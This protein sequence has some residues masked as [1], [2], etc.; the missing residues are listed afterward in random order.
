[1]LAR[2]LGSVLPT[3]RPTNGERIS[4]RMPTGAVSRP[5][6]GGGVAHVLL[7]PQRQQHHVAEEHAVT[8][9]QRERAGPEIAPLEQAQ[10]D[11]RMRHRSAPKP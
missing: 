5:G 7:Q 1:M 11:H 9:R 4:A 3:R 6:I 10:I 8:E 2:I